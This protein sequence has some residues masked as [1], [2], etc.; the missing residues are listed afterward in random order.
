MGVWEVPA[1]NTIFAMMSSFVACLHLGRAQALAWDRERPAAF[2]LRAIET[3]A[4]PG[5]A[6]TKK[7]TG[8]ATRR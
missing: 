8:N 5:E 4:L 3:P 2:S 6:I 7:E 1:A